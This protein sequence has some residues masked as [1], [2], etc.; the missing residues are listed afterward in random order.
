MVETATVCVI[1]TFFQS[2]QKL[3]LTEN[4]IEMSSFVGFDNHNEFINTIERNLMTRIMITG[5]LSIF[6]KHSIQNV[7]RHQ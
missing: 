1:V 4:P 3:V 2:V 7:S 6:S 5:V